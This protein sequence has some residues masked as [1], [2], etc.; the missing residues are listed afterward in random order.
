MSGTALPQV[1][2]G[3]IVLLFSFTVHELA[4]AW[5]ANRLGD[6]T[7]RLLGRITL[8]PMAHADL[9]GTVLLPLI[10][11]LGGGLVVGWAKPVPV[12]VSRLGHPRRDFALVALAGPVSNLLLALVARQVLRV[13]VLAP[14]A[15]GAA[16][17][18][19][20]LIWLFQQALSLNV[21]L[22]VF[23]LLP[24]PP[25]DGAT[26]LQ[27][28]LPRT[29]AVSFDRFVRPYGPMILVGLMLTGAW[30]ALVQRPTLTLLSWLS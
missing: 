16:D 3:F 30:S 17:I 20:P 9:F 24:V 1:L 8:N 14:A 5:V 29:L 21:L 19:T 23:N 4:H 26:V 13:L 25:L 18:A 28:I 27:G 15:R 10:G 11:L 12:Q 22:A 2:L 7:G 6:P